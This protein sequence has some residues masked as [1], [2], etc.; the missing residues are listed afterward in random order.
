MTKDI[1][2]AAQKATALRAS[3]KHRRSAPHDE[4]FSHGGETHRSRGKHE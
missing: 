3:D 1:E 2:I 4:G